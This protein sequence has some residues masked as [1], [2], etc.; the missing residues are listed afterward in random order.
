MILV[1]SGVVLVLT[2]AAFIGYELLTFRRAAVRQLAT[3]GEIIATESTGA[4]AFDNQRDATEILAALKAERQIVAA[5]LY[6]LN[7]RIFARYPAESPDRAFPPGPLADGHRFVDGHLVGFT[8]VVQVKGNQRFGTL[9]L[10]SD[11]SAM[12]E[13][14]QLYAGIAALVVL[15]ASLVAYALSRTFQRQISQP[16]LE[17]ADTARAI[18]TRGDYSVRAHKRGEDELG[19]LTDAFNHMLTQIQEQNELLEKR[20]RERTAELESANNELEAFCS[21]AAHDLRTPLR[22]ITG[23]ADVLLDPRANMPSPEAQRYIRMIR[24]GS[25]Q[26]STLIDDLLAFSR[27]GR[28]ALSRQTVDLNQLCR[29]IFADLDPERRGRRVDLR[30]HH[31]PAADGDPALLRVAFV[32]LLSNA[33]KYSRPRETA[34]IEVGVT[35]AA[36]GPTPVYFVRDN[37]V[38]F[39]MR[40]A[41]KLFGVFQRLHHAHEFEGTGVGLATVR[42]IIDRHGGRI[43]AESSPS[44][45]ATFYFSLSP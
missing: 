24:D 28:Q 2:C 25:G 6:D 3:L 5:C 31:L 8:P 12:N 39:D 38:G 11:M 10:S 42:R 40:D 22:T 32:N 45:G 9:Y 30:L 37:G 7:G 35:I 18:S 20:V 17:L 27:L 1:T 26:M 13:R 36:P 43:W 33:L 16:I 4:V 29:E 14:L 44:Q 21:S 19:V 23:F 34:V 15:L 41:G